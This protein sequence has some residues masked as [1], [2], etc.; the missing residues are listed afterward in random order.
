MTWSATIRGRF[1]HEVPQGLPAPAGHSGHLPGECTTQGASGLRRAYASFFNGLQPCI[2]TGSCRSSNSTSSRRPAIGGWSR[3]RARNGHRIPGTASLH[4]AAGSSAAGAQPTA[5]PSAIAQCL[6][7][8]LLVAAVVR[9]RRRHNPALDRGYPG[10]V[11]QQLYAITPADPRIQRKD[12][13]ADARP[14]PVVCPGYGI[15]PSGMRLSVLLEEGHNS[16]TAPRCTASARAAP[17]V[18]CGESRT[19]R[20]RLSPFMAGHGS[21]EPEMS[22]TRTSRA[23]WDGRAM[24]LLRARSARSLRHPATMTTLRSGGPS[25]PE[26]R[27]A[28]RSITP[29]TAWRQ[30]VPEARYALSAR[31]SESG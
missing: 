31:A 1:P 25:D 15:G 4:C 5:V 17:K 27:R 29:A 8:R 11:Y 9:G 22:T 26:V 24:T 3:S 30:A 28:A 23:A 20:T 10:R 19:H 13:R 18:A 2:C 16:A 21:A 6:Q 7:A 14:R 12:L